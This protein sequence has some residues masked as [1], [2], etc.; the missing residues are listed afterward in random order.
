MIPS[1]QSV[2][3]AGKVNHG[4]FVDQYGNEYTI[5]EIKA[6][7]KNAYEKL[8]NIKNGQKIKID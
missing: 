4:V 1:G 5:E 8:K 6:I 7:D 3:Y 2:R